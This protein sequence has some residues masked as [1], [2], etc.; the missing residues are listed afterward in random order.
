[1]HFSSLRSGKHENIH[2]QNAWNKYGED[3]FFFEVL[4]RNLSPIGVNERE[5]YWIAHFDSFVNGYNRTV[6]GELGGYGRVCVWNGIEYKSISEAAEQNNVTIT[7]MWERLQRGYASDKDLNAPR[8]LPFIWNGITYPSVYIAAK[9]TN[10]SVSAL[11]NR[12]YRGQ[13]SDA[14]MP[15]WKGA[16]GTVCYWNGIQY[17]SI[18]QCATAIGICMRTMLYR[19]RQGYTCDADMKY[20]HK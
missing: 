20:K 15:G 4:E 6:G 7:T 19:F 17:P 1:M 10:V 11:R 16:K 8:A 3:A 5:R 2:L 9:E 18:Q 14:D 13:Q 12:A